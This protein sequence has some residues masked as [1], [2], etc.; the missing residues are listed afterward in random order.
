M[1]SDLS[2]GDYVNF[3]IFSDAGGELCRSWKRF[4]GWIFKPHPKYPLDGSQF[5]YAIIAVQPSS[6]GMRGF[7]RMTVTIKDKVGFITLGQTQ[8]CEAK[9]RFELP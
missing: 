9:T 4:M 2:R 7:V 8:E 6:G 5:V 3:R 1:K